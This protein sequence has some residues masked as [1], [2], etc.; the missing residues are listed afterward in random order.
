MSHTAS[1][2][3]KIGGLLGKPELVKGLT[4]LVPLK[5]EICFGS[6]SCGLPEAAKLKLPG[7]YCHTVSCHLK[8]VRSRQR[9]GKPLQIS[10]SCAVRGFLCKSVPGSP[11]KLLFSAWLRAWQVGLAAGAAQA[12]LR[13]SAQKWRWSPSEKLGGVM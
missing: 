6:F 5:F 4:A 3:T 12:L 8:S 7:V 2:P 13:A 1:P 10:L 11:E 9:K